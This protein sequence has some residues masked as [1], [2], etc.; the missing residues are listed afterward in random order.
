L[1]SDDNIYTTRD[2]VSHKIVLHFALFFQVREASSYRYSKFLSTPNKIYQKIWDPWSSINGVCQCS[3]TCAPCIFPTLMILTTE[4]IIYKA[5][6]TSSKHNTI[7]TNTC[8]DSLSQQYIVPKLFSL[9]SSLSGKTRPCIY[10]VHETSL[11][12]P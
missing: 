5:K 4:K 3:V 1:P 9:F 8:E 2:A 10:Q 7:C 12:K 6:S 11:C